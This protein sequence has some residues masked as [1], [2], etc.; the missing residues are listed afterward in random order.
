MNKN[1]IAALAA[2]V[3]LAQAGTSFADGVYRR[4]L[5]I[6]EDVMGRPAVVR[7]QVVLHP[8]WYSDVKVR[9]A[10]FIPQS[11]LFRDI[12][13]KVAGT[14]D[15]EVATSVLPHVDL[16]ANIDGLVKHGRSLGLNSPTRIGMTHV[17]LGVKFPY[18]LSQRW[19]LPGGRFETR[20]VLYA[21]A[22]ISFASVWLKNKSPFTWE[23]INK[24]TVGGV[25]KSG[26]YCFVTDRV[27]LDLF[28]DYLVQPTHFNPRYVNTGG[29]KVGAGLGTS[30]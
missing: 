17:S 21:G 13:G 11:K 12:Y 1:R 27:F 6:H 2:V 10:A 26:A 4:G 14:F 30:F 18:A 9:G 24:G 8:V 3:A 28:A 25:I 15:V 16:W 19:V 23:R 5:E 22:G 29:L 20:W 7:E